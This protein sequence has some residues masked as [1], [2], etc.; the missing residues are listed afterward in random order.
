MN[1]NKHVVVGGGG[2]ENVIIW[3][4]L[5]SLAALAIVNVTISS[6]ASDKKSIKKTIFSIL[7]LSLQLTWSSGTCRLNLLVPYFQMKWRGWL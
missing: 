1:R 4:K 7:S 6:A 3:T 5:S 2:I